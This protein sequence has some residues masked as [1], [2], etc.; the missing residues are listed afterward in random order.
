[1]KNP[2][3]RK[4]QDAMLAELSGLG[5]TVARDLHAR[6]MAA[7]TPQEAEKLTRAF[8]QVSRGVRQTFALEL[9]IERARREHV[10][11]LP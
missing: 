9:E 11:D 10:L 6:A 5:L 7:E 3:R 4:R 2:T 8:Q 1:M